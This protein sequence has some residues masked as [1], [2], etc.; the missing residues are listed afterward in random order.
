MT[1]EKIEDK[2]NVL[3]VDDDKFLLDMYAMKFTQAGYMVHASLS[4]KNALETLRKGYAADAVVF[5]LIM[6]QE[7]GFCLLD[8]IRNEKLAKGASLI[9]LSN[10][11][12]ET[13]K[14]HAMDLGAT[15]YIVKASMIPSEVVEAIGAEIKK[16]K[17]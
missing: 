8:A 5:D 14:K 17:R 1:D 13:E 4:V 10:Q 16:N 9:A 7:D 3:I 11:S 15:N 6:P 12:D 2:P